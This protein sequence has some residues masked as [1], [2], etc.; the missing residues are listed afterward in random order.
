MPFSPHVFEVIARERQE[1]ILA[2]ATQDRQAAAV[3]PE[4]AV[5]RRSRFAPVLAAL[6][7]TLIRTGEN[8][9]RAAYP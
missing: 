4:N 9:R 1:H 2:E 3:R 8:L 7:E 5:L 6:G